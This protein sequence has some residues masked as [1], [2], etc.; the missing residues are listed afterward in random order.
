[1][2]TLYRELWR[3]AL[4]LTKDFRL[5]VPQPQLGI[6]PAY[7][8]S[9]RSSVKDSFSL[10]QFESTQVEQVFK[11]LDGQVELPCGMGKYLVRKE[12][13]DIRCLLIDAEARKW[14][15]VTENGGRP[16]G[17]ARLDYNISGQ[18]GA[19]MYSLTV[20]LSFKIC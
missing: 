15:G 4:P 13:E 18:P 12:Y 8:V 9:L 16:A 6:W 5:R 11:I 2:Q 10:K 17:Y 3:K 20:S 19:G 14:A 7:K 1:M